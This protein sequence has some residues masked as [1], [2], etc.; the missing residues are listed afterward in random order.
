MLKHNYFIKIK[1]NNAKTQMMSTNER[2]PVWQ[3]IF[4]SLF[5]ERNF[6]KQINDI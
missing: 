4:I 5:Y 3:I 2:T 6:N 1:I